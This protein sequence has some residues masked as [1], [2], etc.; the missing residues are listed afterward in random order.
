MMRSL[1]S[2]VTGLRNQ[3]VKMD[4]IGNN[5]ANVGTAGF[6]KS[7]VVFSDKLYQANRGASAPSD[8]KGGTNPMS[9]GLGTALFSIDQIHTPYAASMTNRLTD[10]AL[11]GDG[12]FI[13]KQSGGSTV[14][15]RSGAFV[16][17]EY[18]N[19]V[20]VN[21][22]FVQGWLADEDGNFNTN[23]TRMENI[24]ITA[25]QNMAPK[26]TTEMI[27]EGNLSSALEAQAAGFNMATDAPDDENVVIILKD[28]YDSLGNK[29]SLSYRFFKTGPDTWACDLSL[30]PTFPDNGGTG[31]TA[32]TPPAA[33]AFTSAGGETF[34][35]EN[36]IFGTDGKIDPTVAGAVTS[37]NVTY[38]NTAVSGADIVNF[39]INLED[40]LQYNSQSNIDVGRQ[41]GNS[42]GILTSRNVGADG[43]MLGTYDNGFSRPMFQVAIASFKN[44][45]GLQQIGNSSWQ[46]SA[47]SGDPQI[48]IPGS[49]SRGAI[50]PGYLEMSNVD[51]A[52]E[53]TE[54]IVTQRGFSANSR[55]ITVSDEMLQELVNIKR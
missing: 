23:P 30:D 45:E 12:Y 55:I 32:V 14:Y 33:A 38:D 48:G 5:I 16:I 26:A 31:Y 8:T 37:I 44:A 52:E 27:M 18:N 22:E 54:M 28:F 25:Y 49:G 17:D 11:D 7:R 41:N 51:L 53:F 43:I 46:E 19:L 29:N 39:S 6:K 3:Q 42:A 50:M 13:V 36:I 24:N 10:M 20:T 40:I 9:V 47:N 4:V 2:G 15:T 21:G 35:I 1:Y 34:R